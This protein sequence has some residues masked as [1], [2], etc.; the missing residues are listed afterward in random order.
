MVPA[1]GRNLPSTWRANAAGGNVGAGGLKIADGVLFNVAGG[2]LAN[3]TVLVYG[4][5]TQTYGGTAS[6]ARDTFL[7]GDASAT[8]AYTGGGAVVFGTGHLVLPRPVPDGPVT[9]W[10][11]PERLRFC[12]AG[13]VPGQVAN[14]VFLGQQWLYEVESAAG[15]LLMV[16]QNDGGAEHAIGT[17]VQVTAAPAGIRLG[18]A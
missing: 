9:I 18:L 5:G 10:I 15:R 8:G 17:P 7:V 14:R 1:A 3:P 2:T 11:R 12:E 4:G 13:G 16:I 6:L